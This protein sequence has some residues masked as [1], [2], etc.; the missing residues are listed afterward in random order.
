MAEYLTTAQLTADRVTTNVSDHEIKG[1]GTVQ[2][3]SLSRHEVIEAQRKHGEDTLAWE[4]YVL[5]RALVQPAMGEH[6]VAEWQK[7]SA[8]GEINAIAKAVNELSGISQ[9]A[10]KSSVD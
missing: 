6:D 2:L 1:L 3:R 7:A 10:D 9:G 5:S 8:P 4:R